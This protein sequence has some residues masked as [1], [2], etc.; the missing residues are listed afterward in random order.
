M[1]GGDSNRY[2]NRNWSGIF[3]VEE[4]RVPLMKGTI[5]SVE[6]ELVQPSTVGVDLTLQYLAGGGANGA[7]V[8]LR[9]QIQP[10]GSPS[11]EQFEG[12]TFANGAVPGARE[13]ADENNA[14]PQEDPNMSQVRTQELALDRFGAARASVGDLPKIYSPKSL[15]MEMEFRDPN[16]EL[17]TISSRF[18]MWPAK[19]LVGINPGSWQMT[20]DDMKFRVAVAD[21]KGKPV[22]NAPVKVDIYEQTTVSSRKRTVGGFYAYEHNPG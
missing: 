15:L 17:Q 19:V 18:P 9:A 1:L 11:F 8:K 4:F 2:W 6:R 21:L 10:T 7:P 20:Q 14:L 13:E 12:F 5:Q 3:R 16:G 22:K